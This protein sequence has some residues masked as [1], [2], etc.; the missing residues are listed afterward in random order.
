MLNNKEYWSWLHGAFLPGVFSGK[1][2]NGQQE[3]QTVYIGNKRS[4]L[5]GM[6]RAR[7]LRVKSS[8]LFSVLTK[9]VLIYSLYIHAV[10]L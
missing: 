7:Q 9:A 1:W 6:A 4:I 8:K 3:N 10:R 2:Y 5:V